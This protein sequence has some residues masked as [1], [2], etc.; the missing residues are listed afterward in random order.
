MS[1]IKVSSEAIPGMAA[2]YSQIRPL[3]LVIGGH[4]GD[5]IQH[6]VW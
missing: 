6:V 1:V 2:A 3:W 4:G 5:P